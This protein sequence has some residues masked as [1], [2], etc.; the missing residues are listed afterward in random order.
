MTLIELRE[1]AVRESEAA[2]AIK[3]EADAE[4]RDMTS[5]EALKF[6]KHLAESERLEKVAER[7]QKLEESEARLNKV[8]ERKSTLETADGA[9]IQIV[10][11]ELF[12]FGQLRAFKGKNAEADAY[13]SG[14]WL[15]ATVMGDAASRQW[16]RDHG[17]EIR[18]QQEGINTAGGFVVPDVMERAIIDLRETYGMYRANSR[19]HPMGS[20][21][22][23]IPRRTGGVTAYFV[24]ET[25][26]IT[27]SDKTWDQVEL[28]AKKLGALTRMSTDLSEDAIINIADDLAQEMAYAFSKKEDECGLDG[29]GTSTYG[30]MIGI[31]TRLMDGNHTAGIYEGT[32]PFTTWA[33][34]TLADEIINVMALLPTYALPRA[35]WYIHPAGK[36]GLMDLIS[37]AAGGNT[38][39][40]IATGAEPMFA[41]YRVVVSSAMPP[42]PVD[43]EICVLFGD[44]AMAATFGDRRGITIKV[45]TERYLEY[46]QIGIMATQRFCIVNHDLGD[47]SLAGPIVGLHGNT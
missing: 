44:L 39:R 42:L 21:H 4:S 18:V 26:E 3:D 43:Q 2:R 29:D 12:R 14:R 36:V 5:E 41:G 33:T 11:P 47:T 40:E 19:V 20:D 23:L 9:D 1:A 37:L 15:M 8:Q 13:K 7:Q 45:S 10:K 22:S 35:K 32:S 6:D 25:D 28:T 24:G 31:R 34:G 30:G 46:D 27:A 17:I 16:C 38:T